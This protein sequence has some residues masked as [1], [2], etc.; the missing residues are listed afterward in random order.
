MKRIAL[1]LILLLLFV[2]GCD[3]VDPGYFNLNAAD[4]D[5]Q[6]SIQGKTSDDTYQVPRIDSATHSLQVIDYEHHEIH[7]G[8]SFSFMYENLCTN[9]NEET[10]IAF[11][12]PDTTSWGHMVANG[13]V[14]SQS[15]LAIYESPS[16]DNDE[17]TQASPLNRNRNSTRISAFTSVQAVPVSGNVTT[18]NESQASTA[19]IN[20][21]PLA[22]VVMGSPGFLGIGAATGG[23]SGRLEWILRQN[24]QYAFV[25]TSLDNNDNYHTIQL[26]WYEHTNREP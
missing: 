16:I 18:Y 13:F 8:R 25:I 20:G 12:T 15:R 19:N 5:A 3:Q 4:D 14:T 17:G 24:T 6:V 23:N 1:L 9:T 21:I 10:V 11:N 7:I 2:T 22:V 26:N